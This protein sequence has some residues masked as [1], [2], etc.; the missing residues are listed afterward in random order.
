MVLLYMFYLHVAI[1]M[2]V[3][4]QYAASLSHVECAK[5]QL[6]QAALRTERDAAKQGRLGHPQ[7]IHGEHACAERKRWMY[8]IQYITIF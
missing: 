3:R 4:L 1:E 7:D 6:E 5:R 2:H 8:G